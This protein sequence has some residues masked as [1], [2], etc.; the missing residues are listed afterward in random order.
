MDGDVTEER[1]PAEGRAGAP[2]RRLFSLPALVAFGVAVA[3]LAFLVT[4]FDVDLAD[5]YQQVRAS[6]PLFY[7]LAFVSY[8]ASFVVRGAR[9]R[10][11]AKHAGVSRPGQRLPTLWECSLLT[12]LG[13]FANSVG[14]L[15]AGD[16]YRAYAFSGAARSSFSWSLG[17][18]V[19]DRVLDVA[20]MVVLL[21]VAALVLLATG[22]VVPSLFFVL[23]GLALAGA[24]AAGVAFMAW[25][26]NPLLR[27]LPRPLSRA[28]EGLR[29][30]AL[31]SL[32]PMPGAMVLGMLAWLLEAGRL[33]LVIHA[34]GL[35]LDAPA[36]LFVAVVN[37]LLTSVPVTP[38]G[39]GIVEPGI[40]GL[41][42]LSLSQGDAVA[43]AVLDRSVSYVS[44]VLLGGLAFLF[45]TLR[46]R[47]SAPPA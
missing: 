1:S 2:S 30:G 41:L 35:S 9:W 7:A 27:W 14:W 6:H 33:L 44:V 5:T 34:L 31:G 4:R 19:A 29:Q 15:R 42:A 17:V 20:A 23:I 40:V 36:V 38:G 18:L 11:T 24:A 32:R 37:G 25:R 39:L 3:F 8:Y 47:R 43:V 45:W 46:Q 16:A 10:L 22:G 21:W 28:Y 26:G 13:W 12:L